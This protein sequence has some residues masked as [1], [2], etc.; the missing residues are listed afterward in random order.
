MQA[1]FTTKFKSGATIVL[2]EQCRV[3]IILTMNG[4]VSR[5]FSGELPFS[6]KAIKR[7]IPR[8]YG[9]GN[10]HSKH[11]FLAGSTRQS[12]LL[13]QGQPSECRIAHAIFAGFDMTRKAILKASISVD[14]DGD[15]IPAIIVM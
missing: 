4:A 12:E 1:K 3:P 11:N 13:L 5:A 10:T 7:S 14:L 8:A 15:V 6:I 2:P 9:M